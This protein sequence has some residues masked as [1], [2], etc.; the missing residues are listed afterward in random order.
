M[1]SLVEGTSLL[2]IP[3]A[4]MAGAQQGARE[5]SRELPGTCIFFQQHREALR[6]LDPCRLDDGEGEM[7]GGQ[8][9]DVEDHMQI[10]GSHAAKELHCVLARLRVGRVQV[11]Y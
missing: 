8:T 2:P 5:K 10:V 6:V 7:S 3:D 11:I 4:V 1:S 9:R